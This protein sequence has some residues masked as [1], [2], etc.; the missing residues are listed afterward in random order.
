MAS[1]IR[2]L[3]LCMLV[4]LIITSSRAPSVRAQAPAAPRPATAY[5]LIEAVNSYRGQNGLPAST[6]RSILMGTAQ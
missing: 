5:E 3:Y 4:M 1:R 2:P 6:V